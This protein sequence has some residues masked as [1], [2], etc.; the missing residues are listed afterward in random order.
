MRQETFVKLSALGLGLVLVSFL[1]R[2]FSQFLVSPQ[3]ASVLSAP[4]MLVGGS[5]IV[6]LTLRSVLA[7]SGLRPLN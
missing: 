7:I 6:L 2:G 1:I 5:L 3:T 4:T